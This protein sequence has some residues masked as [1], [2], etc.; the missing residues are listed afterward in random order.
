MAGYKV[1]IEGGQIIERLA[2][3]FPMV[4]DAEIV[5]PLAK[6]GL[7]VEKNAK[8]EAP[9]FM[10]HLRA[11]ITNEVHASG[12]KA[13]VKIGPSLGATV[14]PVV[15][16]YGRKPG[17]PPPVSALIRWV[18][19]V[20]KPDPEDEWAIARAIARKIGARGFKDRPDGWQYMKKGLEKTEPKIVGWFADAFE[21]MLERIKK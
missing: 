5:K 20:I 18:H 1:R 10:G 6:I 21:R 13:F 7:E 14:Y 2:R 17:K 16:E 15:I 19:L 11:S 12:G 3:D 4:F 9:A 8:D